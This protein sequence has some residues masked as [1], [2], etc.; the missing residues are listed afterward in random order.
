MAN[1]RYQ[2]DLYQAVN[3]EWQETAVIPADQSRTG[4]FNDLADDV[5]KKLMADFAAVAAGT[6]PA[7]DAEFGQAV[8]LYQKAS[9]WA[10]RDAAGIQPVLNRLSAL[11]AVADFTSFN[12]S[13]ASLSNELFPLPFTFS[14]DPDMKNTKQNAVTLSGPSLILPDTTYYADGN[15]QAAKLRQVWHDMATK[16]LAQTDL[17]TADQATYVAD[18]EAFDNELAKHVKSNEEWADYPKAYNPQSFAEVA[19]QFGDFDF[20]DFA[21]TVFPAKPDPVIVADPRFLAE[22]TQLFSADTYSRYQHWAYVTELLSNTGYLSNDLR[23]LGGTYGRALSGSPEAPSQAKHAYRLANQFFSEPVG[24]YYGRTYFGEAAKADVTNLVEK[25]IATYKRRLGNSWLSDA[26][27][28]KAITKLDTMVLKMGYPDA[29]DPV[30]AKLSV[31]PADD[32]LTAVTKL[33]QVRHADN[34]AKLT[35][36]VNRNEWAMPGHLVNACYDPSRNDITFPAAILQAPFYALKQTASENLGGIGAVIAHEISHGFD[37]NGAQFDEFGNLSNWW[38]DADYAQFKTK[39]QQMI[40]EFDGLE[41]EGGKVNGRLIV[42]ENIADAGGL[43][44]ALETAQNLPDADLRAF[45]MNWARIWRQ[46][47]RVEFQQFMLAI[48]VHAP[49]KLRANIQPRNLDA[50]YETFDVQPGDGMYLEPAKR[51]HIW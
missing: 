37:N 27:K 14:V 22:F 38:T 26:T 36:P 39:T 41:T 5:E 21:A 31:A 50:W 23:I 40:D 4:G 20:T 30:Y 33:A 47:A 35:K 7:P 12:E 11:Q 44:A 45:F 42:S 25:M 48:D 18:A 2:D 15:A 6:K 51:V 3:G 16:V 13:A 9:D 10:T 24:I 1:A 8:A 29:A 28:T 19:K 43:A 34:L 17:S 32:L 46:K 49:A